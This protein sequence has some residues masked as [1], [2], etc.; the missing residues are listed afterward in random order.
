MTAGIA[1]PV[2]AQGNGKQSGFTRPVVVFV[3]ILVV[4]LAAAGILVALYFI[5]SSIA[6]KKSCTDDPKLI[7]QYNDTVRQEGV[8]KLGAI[9]EDVKNKEQYESDPTC[10][11]IA[12][13]AAYGA[14]ST[15]QQLQAYTK[16][17]SL[18]SQGKEVSEKIDDGIDRSAV[19]G[20]LQRQIKEEEKIKENG[21]TYAGEG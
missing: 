12:L 20:A 17:T 7:Q 21:Q 13:I 19:E 16:L 8:T 1:Q 4:A 10:Q 14:Q 11:Y 5:N 9:A 6:A 2:S 15:D 3:L 18:Q